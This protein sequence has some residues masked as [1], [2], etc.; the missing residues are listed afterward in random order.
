MTP[1][2]Q[3][4]PRACQRCKNFE[5][6]RLKGAVDL[7]A[8]CRLKIAWFFLTRPTVPANRQRQVLTM[9]KRFR[10]REHYSIVWPK[11]WRVKGHLVQFNA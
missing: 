9:P 10:P 1:L 3:R 2:R 6:C 7:A 11:C 8:I 4:V 5:D